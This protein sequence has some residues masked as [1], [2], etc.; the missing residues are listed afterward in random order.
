MDRIEILI[1][2]SSTQNHEFD[3][4]LRFCLYQITNPRYGI[5]YYQRPQLRP[6]IHHLP[7][8]LRSPPPYPPLPTQGLLPL[9]LS[10]RTSH[11]LTP[12]S[13]VPHQN[14]SL[15]CRLLRP[16]AQENHHL[17]VP[18]RARPVFRPRNLTQT[19]CS[20]IMPVLAEILVQLDIKQP[21][22]QISIS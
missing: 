2:I 15:L 7:T 8:L 12:V 6:S 5:T 10:P 17:L 13:Q 11:V 14:T 20:I 4:Y 16:Q 22:N 9:P 18:T 3:L 19:V 1:N 21:Q